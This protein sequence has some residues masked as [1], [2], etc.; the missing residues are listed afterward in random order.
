MNRNKIIIIHHVYNT[1][2]MAAW[3]RRIPVCDIIISMDSNNKE[4]YKRKRVYIF[5]ADIAVQI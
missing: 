2:M 3:Q 4:D 5:D 1:Q